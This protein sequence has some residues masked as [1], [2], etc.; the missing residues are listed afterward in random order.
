MQTPYGAIEYAD[1]GSGPVILITHGILGG[2]DQGMLVTHLADPSQRPFRIISVSRWGY[3]RTPI[4]HDPALRTAEAQADAYEAL[5]DTLGIDKVAM[6]GISGGGPSAIQF[7]LRHPE[8][9]WALVSIAG[10]T[11]PI[12]TNF[13]P[14]RAHPF[15]DREQRPGAVADTNLRRAQDIEFLRRDPRSIGAVR[16][17]ARETDSAQ[18]CVL[19]SPATDEEGRLRARPGG[20][21]LLSLPIRWSA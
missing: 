7:A 18:G 4:P 17:P 16:E 1:E 5:L 12:I 2:W 21:S 11:R 6:V 15:A 14:H 19:P 3:L 8:R 10:V 9:C 13:Q 20:V